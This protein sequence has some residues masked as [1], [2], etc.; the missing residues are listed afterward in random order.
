MGK[1]L[2]APKKAPKSQ[3]AA[4]SKAQNY[5]KLK[6]RFDPLGKHKKN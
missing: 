1:Y 3:Q 6:P 4:K 5:L 2:K